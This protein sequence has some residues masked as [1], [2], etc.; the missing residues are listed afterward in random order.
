LFGGFTSKNWTG[1]QNYQDDPDAF[2]FNLQDK[3]TAT[4]PMKAI[5][6][7]SNGFGFGDGVL[8]LTAREE[9]CLNH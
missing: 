5:Y 3:Y 6:T 9:E 1:E 2:V 7:H 8:S 4:D